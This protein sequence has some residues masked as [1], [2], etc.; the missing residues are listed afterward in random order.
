MA[1][2]QSDIPLSSSLQEILSHA[3]QGPLYTYPTS[4]T[5]GI[6]PKAMH[7]HND[8]WRPIP[9]YSALAAGAISVEADVWLYDGTLHVGH[10]ESALTNERTL[11]SL[12][13]QPILSVLQ[14]Q[15]PSNSSFVH[16]T[17]KNG[18]FDTN[19]G[20]TLY[21]FIDVKT[22]G[23]STWPAVVKALQPLRSSGYLST[24]NGT[25]VTAG[26]VTV[27]G[28]GNT[29]LS[30]VQE[31]SP[32]DFFYDAS[33]P[34]LNT[35]QS[36]ITSDVSPIASTSFTSQFGMAKNGTLTA[37]QTKLLKAQ[38]EMAHRK[39]IKVRYWDQPLWPVGTRNAVWRLLWNAGADL[40]NVDD[41]EG[42]ANFWQQQG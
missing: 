24:F 37:A 9:F 32:R 26:P 21:L 2:S 23:P 7:S 31:V 4:L 11:D 35:A 41:L 38:I 30:Q 33:L 10:E 29:P 16:G 1:N 5:Q 36:N 28:T 40:I 42:A 27:I 13:I 17:T 22:D 3:H 20:Q 39:N 34:V 12:Y 8:Y 6:I 14:A 18:V 15:N 19:N 25:G